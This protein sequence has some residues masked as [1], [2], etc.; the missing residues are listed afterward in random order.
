MSNDSENIAFLI[1][2]IKDAKQALDAGK[3]ANLDPVI[4]E[5]AKNQADLFDNEGV[6]NT[7]S[8]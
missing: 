6:L 3:L 4:L 8:P 1:D 2:Q 7:D 5:G